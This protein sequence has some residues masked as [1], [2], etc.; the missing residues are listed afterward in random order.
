MA[1]MW[2]EGIVLW[3]GLLLVVAFAVRVT[4]G[5]LVGRL[6][7]SSV[8]IEPSFYQV[9]YLAGGRR[10]VAETALG[11]LILLGVVEVREQTRRLVLRTPPRPD[12][13]LQPVELALVNSIPMD[14]IGPALPLAAARDGARRVEPTMGGLCIPPATAVALR[15]LT[16][17]LSLV[18]ALGVAVWSVGRLTS[19]LGMGWAPLLVPLAVGLGVWGGS[20]RPIRTTVG[21]RLLAEMRRRHDP[22]LGMAAIGVTSLPAERAM[23]IVALYGRQMLTGGLLGL[24]NL[25]VPR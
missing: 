23:Y 9:A 14:G 16:A 5:F 18:V 13:P 19:G 11:Y 8:P 20:A 22:D 3:A 7:R 24:R 15:A 12:D 21:R 1:G 4:V 10:R 17:T 2:G 25:L 6:H